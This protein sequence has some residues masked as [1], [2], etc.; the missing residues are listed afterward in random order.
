ME[1][2][3]RPQ[4]EQPEKEKKELNEKVLVLAKRLDHI[5]RAYRKE[6]RPLLTK[7]Y[8]IQ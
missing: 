3:M 6:E 8:E 2:L 1:N 7:D 4:V 5:E